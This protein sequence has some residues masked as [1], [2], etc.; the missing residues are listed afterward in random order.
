METKRAN[1]KAPSQAAKVKKKSKKKHSPPKFIIQTDINQKILSIINSSLSKVFSKCLRPETK[2]K[3][4]QKTLI[5]GIK[6][7]IL[8]IAIAL[9]V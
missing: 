5:K 1:P 2:A 9:I 4:P 3:P 8:R 7:I 6:E